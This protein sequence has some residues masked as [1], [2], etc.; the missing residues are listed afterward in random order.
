ME[1]E[2]RFR[3]LLDNTPEISVQGYEADGTTFYWNKASEVLYGYSKEEAVGKNLLDL[4]IPPPMHEDVRAAVSQMAQ[5]GVPIPA[6][7]LVLQRKGGEPVQVFSG[8]AVVQLPGRPSQ[9]FCM[10]ID[11]SVRKEQEANLRDL[12]ASHIQVRV[13]CERFLAAA[14]PTLHFVAGGREGASSAYLLEARKAGGEVAVF[15]FDEES[16][17]ICVRSSA[18]QTVY[19]TSL[20][21]EGITSMRNDPRTWAPEVNAIVHEVLS[22]LGYAPDRVLYP[23]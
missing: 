2:L 14:K 7:E 19:S 13:A 22:F 17:S 1:S 16:E 23:R 5:S 4:I 8:H 6:G 20:V 11:L 21:L 9:I 3:T 18:S 12:F 15:A 10:D